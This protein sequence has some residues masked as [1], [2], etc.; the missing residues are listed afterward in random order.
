MI[1][2]P[3]GG[4]LSKRDASVAVLDYEREGFVPDGVIN[5]LVR[6]GWSH[7]D[8]EIFTRHELCEKFDWEHVGKTGGQ[9]D[10]KKFQHVQASHLRMK[11][12]AEVAA[13]VLPF[14]ERRGLSVVADDPR[15]AVAVEL[16]LPRATTLV[17][18]ADGLDFYFREPPER[19]EKAARKFLTPDG[20][21]RTQ[22]LAAQVE[23]V[24]PFERDVL[25]QV[26]KGWLEAE[27]LSLKDVAQAARVA[28]TGRS[29]S[30]GLFEVME[31]LGKARTL[32]RLRA[33]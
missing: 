13:L 17:D 25:E 26:V 24:E 2:S 10:I 31:V 23:S 6:L 21:A 20:K 14:L 30:P 15:L 32:E 18:L 12:P 27:G 29:A 1:L 9:F 8:Q 22:A 28:L 19:D 7:G 5:Y 4:K 33:A 16:G 11:T 3:K